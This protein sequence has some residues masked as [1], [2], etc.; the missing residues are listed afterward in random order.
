MRTVAVMVYPRRW[1][2]TI[3]PLQLSIMWTRLEIL[4]SNQ[5]I[6]REILTSNQ[7]FS[8]EYVKSFLQVYEVVIQFRWC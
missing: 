4:T 8:P 3:D 5:R 6:F 7:H 2:T 1:I